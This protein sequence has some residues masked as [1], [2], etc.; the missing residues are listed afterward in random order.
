M[1]D[2]WHKSSYSNTGSQCVEVRETSRGADMRDT[3]NR[4]AGHLSFPAG[5][6]SALLEML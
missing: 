2:G 5:E 4:E 6:W 1:T 3:V